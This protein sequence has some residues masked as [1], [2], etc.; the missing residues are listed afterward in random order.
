M[1]DGVQRVFL[2]SRD[3]TDCIRTQA[4]SEGASV[5]ASH[6]AT[7]TKLVAKQQA[8]AARVPV[9]MDG[10]DIGSQVLPHAQ[11]KIYLD[12]SLETRTHRRVFDLESRGLPA[13]FEKVRQETLRRD[14]RDK[15]R[16]A[17]PLVR[18]ADAVLI[19]TG[20]MHPQEVADEIV[21]IVMQNGE[22]I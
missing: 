11:V 8:M 2:N 4:V 21:S 14:T 22:K 16:A 7:R 20:M 10:R 17:G 9:V 6:A 1:E 12:A 13:D 5:V 19:D 18:V 15:T 3:V